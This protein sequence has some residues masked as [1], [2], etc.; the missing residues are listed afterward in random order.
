MQPYL[1]IWFNEDEKK[2]EAE[3][4]VETVIIFMSEVGGIIKFMMMAGFVI[5]FPF[6]NYKFEKAMIKRLYL[7]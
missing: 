5:S 7:V 3:R 6:Q 1:G 4:T 2:G